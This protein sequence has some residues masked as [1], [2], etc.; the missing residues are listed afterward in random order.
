MNLKGK[1]FSLLVGA[2]FV[3]LLC[4][5]S[6]TWAQVAPPLGVA[7]QFGALGNSGVTG[8][9]GSG[10]LVSGDVGS[11]PTPSIS[12]FPPSST[13]PPFIVHNTG[14]QP[15]GVVQQAHADA[16]AAYTAL[17]VQGPGTVL[18]DNLTGAVLTSGIYSFISGAPD[19]P[20]SATLTLNGPGIFVFN[21]GSTVTANVLSKV[22]GTAN[23]CNVYWRVGTS[24]TLNGVNFWGTVIA[25]ASITLGSS[26]NV[27]GRLLAGTGATGAVTMAG[28]G[29]NT[30]G[31]C[32]LATPTLI[33]QAS[34]GVTLGAAISDTATL[35]GGV[36]PTG[37][38][39]FKL[40]GPNDATC[41]GVAIFTSVVPVNGNGSY[42]STTFTPTL[43]GTY[44]WIATYSGDANNA[45][46]A[47]A[48]NAV[49]EI[50]IIAPV[51]AIIPTLTTQA[52]PTVTLGAAISDTATLSGGLAPTG[53]ITFKLYGPND[54]TCTSAAIFT[55]TV[56]VSGNGVYPS[57]SFTPTLAGTYR[58]IATYSGDANNAAVATACD[59]VNENVVVAPVGAG[60]PT[61]T[62]Q[63]SPAVTLG[64]AISDTAT[65][66]GGLAPTGTITFKLY[67]PNDATCTGV[68]IFTSV[69]PVSGNGSYP[70]LS[71]TPTVAGIYRWI[72]NYSGDAN[73]AATTNA[74]NA[75]NEI[76]VVAPVGATIPTLTTQASAG[77]ALG[78]SI[79][80]TATL[81]GGVGPTGTITF[82]LYGPNDAT[83]T[84]AAIFTSTVPVSGNGIYFS[85]SFTPTLAGTYR[86][87]VNYSGDANNAPTANACNAA[88]ESVVVGP[89]AAA[90]PTLSEW[91]MVMMAALLVLSGMTAIRR[92][93]M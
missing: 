75:V 14:V 31:G 91:A 38:I 18:P 83:C 19:L 60:L 16:I 25:N 64:A 82:K 7:Q 39:T 79:R 15:D 21:V 22:V 33:T 29:G 93:A 23:P 47:T 61:M 51:G 70:S 67:G 28:S 58:W 87:I 1:D 3:A 41:T 89:A 6:T 92:R 81:S 56:P 35:S 80:D 24:A 45:A 66:S 53:T 8:A 26:A 46:V 40:Y 76:V 62:T 5:A 48:C 71:F 17:Q 2:G 77:V 9:T 85:A 59:V 20:A 52:S 50:V 44:R 69:V 54:A 90:I 11:S 30:I 57:T 36:A 43:A 68:A 86:W 84:N 13:T 65:L 88:N 55:S 63:A 12:N 72:A 74:C 4:V 27:V 37:T 78:A 42:P 34:P 32:S 49:N 10:V 73:N